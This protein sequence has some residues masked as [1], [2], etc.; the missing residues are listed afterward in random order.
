MLKDYMKN[1]VF[2]ETDR[3]LFLSEDALKKGIVKEHRLQNGYYRNIEPS[4]SIYGWMISENSPYLFTYT[5]SLSSPGPV[6]TK[7]GFTSGQLTAVHQHNYIELAYVIQ[8]EFRLKILDK[9]ILFKEGESVLISQAVPH[10]EYIYAQDCIVLFLNVQNAL[11]QLLFPKK[12]KDSLENFVVHLLLS[13]QSNYNYLQFVPRLPSD[14]LSTPRLLENLIR[15][16]R[17]KETGYTHVVTGYILRLFTYLPLEY[18][19]VLDKKDSYQLK[20]LLFDDIKETIHRNYK[21]ITV[22]KLQAKYHY[23]ADYFNRLIQQFSGQTFI[24]FRQNVRLETAGKLLLNTDLCIEEIARETGYENQ[25]YFY[26]I[27]KEK[28]SMTPF[29]YRKRNLVQ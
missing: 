5:D 9:T 25:G 22:E 4:V 19:F 24:G 20:A 17:N 21:D 28:Y 18:Q 7:S 16:I 2:S 10:C 8:G 3:I 11:F 26:R 14:T 27:F 29:Q 13:N 23:N 15:E 1:Y 6:Y 12:A